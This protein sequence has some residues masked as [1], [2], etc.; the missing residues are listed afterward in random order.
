MKSEQQKRAGDGQVPPYGNAQQLLAQLEQKSKE[1]WEHSLRVERYCRKLGPIMGLSDCEL[2]QLFRLAVFHDIGKLEISRDILQK[3]GSLT[4]AEWSIMRQ[5]P[6]AGCHI[7][8]E[9]PE[10]HEIAGPILCHHEHWNGSGYP[11][12]LRQQEIPYPCRILAVADAFDAMT[13]DRSYRKAMKRSDA[14]SELI[15]SA[16]KQF[17]PAIVRRFIDSGIQSL[18]SS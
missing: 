17:D 5:H 1:T 13:S 12:G 15:R 11:K 14:V 6:Q 4:S 9:I 7:A 18:V 8:A 10:I 16:G 3:P 2:E